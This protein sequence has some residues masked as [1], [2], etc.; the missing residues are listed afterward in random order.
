M[1]SKSLSWVQI[2]L[3][4]FLIPSFTWARNYPAP[5]ILREEAHPVTIQY[6]SAEKF[7]SLTQEVG[8]T[9][10]IP[11][12]KDTYLDGSYVG[13]YFYRRVSTYLKCEPLPLEEAIRDSLLQFLPLHGIEAV[14]ISNWDGKE[15]SLKNIE[16]DS[17]LMI[18]IRRFWAEGT[19]HGRGANINTSIYLIIR[20]GVKKEG[21]VF[22]RDM[23]TIKED[24]MDGLTPDAMEQVINQ[25]LTEILD[26]YFSNPY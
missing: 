23:Y 4:C 12:F 1:K 9:V 2:F 16:T 21:K 22:R 14:P 18:E 8:L 7:P 11:P 6:Q 19:V 15:E 17:I 24:S 5:Y 26:T 10:G 20:L 3:F 13:H 25:T